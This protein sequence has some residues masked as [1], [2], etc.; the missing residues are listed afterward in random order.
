[1]TFPCS[2]RV[3]VLP[4]AAV[5]VRFAVVV[6]IVAAAVVVV[7]L[8]MKILLELHKKTKMLW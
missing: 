3:H 5:I 4:F 6:F 1:M 7:L 2:E 8:M